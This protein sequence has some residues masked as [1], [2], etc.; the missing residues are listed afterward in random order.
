MAVSL[1][2]TNLN[3]NN[4]GDYSN[5]IGKTSSVKVASQNA[6][7]T[8]ATDEKVEQSAQGDTVTISSAGSA[9]SQQQT[10]SQAT[11]QASQKTFTGD[12]AGKE[13]GYLKVSET[14]TDSMAGVLASAAADAGITDTTSTTTATGT[15]SSSSD[16][17]SSDSS[18]DLSSYTESQ[19]LT[20]LNNGE[21]TQ[22]QYNSE[23]E[24]RKADDTASDNSAQQ[25]QQASA[26]DA[27]QA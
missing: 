26:A 6:T 22:S 13:D 27:A 25:N 5:S 19:L 12:I 18:D 23:I 2:A 9:L 24:S 4:L 17:S 3:L 11:N 21:I 1:N 16:S 7:T 20:M 8:Q 14:Q 10:T 15:T